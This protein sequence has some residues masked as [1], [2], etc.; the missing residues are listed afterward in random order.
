MNDFA[1]I[2]DCFNTSERFIDEPR[3]DTDAT[4]SVISALP[5]TSITTT[6]RATASS[7]NT[8]SFTTNTGKNNV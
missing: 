4:T 1:L 7:Y 2:N 6:E 3:T 8:K 5:N